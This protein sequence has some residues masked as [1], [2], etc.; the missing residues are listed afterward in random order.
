MLYGV[1]DAVP[2]KSGYYAGQQFITGKE[3]STLLDVIP[4]KQTGKK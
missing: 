3:L 4:E 1:I 2:G